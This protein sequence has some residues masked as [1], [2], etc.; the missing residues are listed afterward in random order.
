MTISVR[1]KFDLLPIVQSSTFPFFS[2]TFFDSFQVSIIAISL[3]S[4]AIVYIVDFQKRSSTTSASSTS[5]DE[6]ISYYE[7]LRNDINVTSLVTTT[8]FSSSTT[9]TMYPGAKDI[10]KKLFTFYLGRSLNSTREP[11]C[12]IPFTHEFTAFLKSVPWTY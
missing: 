11:C 10:S 4:I 8:P 12:Q 7:R 2:M 5:P 3:V 1:I 9:S 6:G